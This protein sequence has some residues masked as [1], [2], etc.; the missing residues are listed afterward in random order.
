MKRWPLEPATAPELLAFY[1]LKG[2]SSVR[3]RTG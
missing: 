1:E 3:R 2:M